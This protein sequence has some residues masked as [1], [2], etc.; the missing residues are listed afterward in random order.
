ML[1]DGSPYFY[2][3]IL[4][5]CVGMGIQLA[6]TFFGLQHA[7]RTPTLYNFMISIAMLIYFLAFIPLLLTTGI[8]FVPTTSID[9]LVASQKAV[10]VI[11][12]FHNVFLGSSTLIYVLLIQFR[13]RSIKALYNYPGWID[14][15]FV[16]VTF[17][18]W[19]VFSFLCNMI[20]PLIDSN[21]TAQIQYGIIWSIYVLLVD[22]V[23]SFVFVMQIYKSRDLFYS[24]ML[25]KERIEAHNCMHSVVK[26]V[27]LLSS[28]SWVCIAFA[29]ASGYYYGPK[30]PERQFLYRVGFS[31]SPLMYSGALVFVYTVR[32]LVPATA[33]VSYASAKDEPKLFIE[34]APRPDYTRPAPRP[35]YTRP[36]TP[37]QSQWSHES[38][39]SSASFKTI[40]KTQRSE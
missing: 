6:N 5:T 29:F 3:E 13:F 20:V 27:Y 18:I 38:L 40:L 22:N 32:K 26:S 34:M 28:I 1:Q 25:P 4:F 16:I 35:D 23:I 37:T 10:S 9:V 24:M 2:W 31:F 19:G 21:S 7:I 30:P 39:Y 17:S 8:G 33:E 14:Q 36:A 12:Y 11:S 15:L